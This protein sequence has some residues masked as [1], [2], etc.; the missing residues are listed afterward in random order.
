MEFFV[1]KIISFSEEIANLEQAVQQHQQEL[2][3]LEERYQQ[4]N[5]QTHDARRA[6]EELRTTLGISPKTTRGRRARV[7][8]GAS[9]LE[10]NP[11]SGRPARGARR[12]QIEAICR[13]LSAE[14]DSFRT[15]EVIEQIR[16]LEG[17]LSSSLRSYVYA[18]MTTLETEG[19]L[20]K[21]GHGRWQ[22]IG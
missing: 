22:V 14:Q 10:T 20:K 1:T 2:V 19:V 13:A 16:H 11:D 5:I 8:Y 18:L 9:A 4:F 6:L 7:A 15:A 3:E 12:A 17:D 21:V